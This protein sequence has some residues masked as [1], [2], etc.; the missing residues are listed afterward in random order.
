[1]ERYALPNCLIGRTKVAVYKRWLARKAQAHRRRDRKRGNHT[2][3]ITEYKQAIHE[4][5]IASGERDRF[6]GE[7]LDWSLISTYD[8]EL[9]K[10]QRRKYKAALSLLPTVDHID[11]GTGP[12]NFQ[13]C[14]WR[15]NDMKNDIPCDDFIGFCRS[16]VA[17]ADGH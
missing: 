12:A 11:D 1:M 10:A 6:T 17:W 13:I 16:V 5:V 2:A 9:S 15:T 14:G 3:T 4:A 8:N 7:D